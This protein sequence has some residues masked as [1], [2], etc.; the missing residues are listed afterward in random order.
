MTSTSTD[1]IIT[2]GK[3]KGKNLEEIITNEK[4]YSKWLIGQKWCETDH[5]DIYNY[6]TKHLTKDNVLPIGR[7]H[8]GRTIEEIRAIDPKYIEFLKKMEWL[9]INMPE[10]YNSL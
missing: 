5:L 9:K 8:K 3:H 10:L 1:L 2:F 6:L 7:K 4:I